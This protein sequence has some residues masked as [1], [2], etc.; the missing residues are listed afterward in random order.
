MSENYIKTNYKLS[1]F[2]TI[3]IPKSVTVTII[4]KEINY[5]QNGVNVLF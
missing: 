5:I 2:V 1:Y 3:I 4:Y